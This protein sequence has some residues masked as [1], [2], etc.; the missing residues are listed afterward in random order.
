M[1][2]TGWVLALVLMLT[3]VLAACGGGSKE[4]S[5]SPEPSGSQAA[6]T[7]A[8]TD[9][10]STE[11]PAQEVTLKVGVSPVPHAEILNLLVPVL[12]EQGVNLEVVEFSDYL[13]PNIQVFEKQLDAN[14]FQHTPYLE[15]FNADHG[16]DLVNV[17]SV[18]VEPFGVYSDKI[19]SID[20]LKDGAKIAIPND[21]SNGGRSLL[22]LAQHGLIELDQN[23]GVDVTVADIKANPRKFEIVELEAAT[24]PRVLDQVDIAAINTNFALE[25]NL[26]PVEDAL[27]IED[28]DSPYV[29]I[30]VT[31]PDNKDDEA[32]QKL[33][34]ALHSPEV[35]TFINETYKGA[36]VPAFNK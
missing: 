30:L 6:A 21:P 25:A 16:Y 8:P 17:A 23:A 15:K 3:V 32:I 12:K 10:S 9:G 34:K 36:V 1:K 27:F 33:I 26:N 31:R 7:E 13:Q 2:K 11:A 14:F 19:T 28:K 20:E 4:G 29:N 35:E 18:H 24:L 5:A 22:L